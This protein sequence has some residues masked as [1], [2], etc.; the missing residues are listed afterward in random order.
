MAF[1]KDKKYKL[2]RGEKKNPRGDRGSYF[3]HRVY[4]LQALR[5]IP[6]HGVKAG[7]FGGLVTN[8]KTLSHAGSCWIGYDAEV[9]GWAEIT[10][11]AY[12]G[13]NAS[14]RSGSHGY[15]I[16]IKDNAKITGNAIIEMARY[17]SGFTCKGPLEIS[18]NAHIYED[19]LLKNVLKIS[20]NAKIHGDAYLK[21]T[22]AVIDSADIFGQSFIGLDVIVIGN[23]KIHGNARIEEKATIRNSDISHDVIIPKYETVGERTLTNM[24][25]ISSHTITQDKDFTSSTALSLRKS[26]LLGIY[27]DVVSKIDAYETDIVKIIKYPSMTDRSHKSTLEMAMAKMTAERMVADPECEDV[28][29]DES[30]KELEEKFL[31]AESY[32]LKLAKTA[33]SEEENKKVTKAQDLLSLAAN[34]ASSDQEK[35][36]AFQQAFK[37]LEGVLVVPE[38]AV[39]IFRIKVGLKEIEA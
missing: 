25:Q 17:T 1:G 33:L 11:N 31:I 21:G 24:R 22:N 23:S 19:A 36:V 32:A 13:D 38:A 20:D 16:A 37:Q 29:L 26:K 27:H 10:G 12:I 9:F 3:V 35:K 2:I 34:E 8:S 39:D 18:G 15:L 5:D 6:E 30:V 7:D 14:I 4:R 28:E